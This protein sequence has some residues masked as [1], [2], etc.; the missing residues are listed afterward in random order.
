MASMNAGI[1]L[2]GQQPNFLDIVQRGN[3]AAQQQNQFTRQN[4]LNALYRDQGAQIAQ[5]DQGALNALAGF[6]PSA[7][8][9]VQ[10]ARLGMDQTRQNMQ[11]NRE[12][13]AL[14]KQNAARQAQQYVAQMGAE[15]AAQEAEQIKRGL[16]AAGRAFDAGDEAGFQ[17]ILR[18]NGVDPFPMEEFPYRAAEYAGVLETLEKANSYGK[19]PA[20]EY[21]VTDGQFYDKNNPQAG[22]Q[23]LPGFKAEPRAPLVS[24]VIGGGDE[25]YK[26]LDKAQGDMFGSL[27]QQGVEAPAKLAQIDQLEAYLGDASTPEGIEA[28]L[29]AFAGDLGIPTEGLDKLQAARAIISQLVP[30]QRPPGSGTMSDA[31]LAL[32]QQSLPRMINTREGNLMIIRTLRGIAQYEIG[33]AQ[34]AAALANREISPAEA[35]K[36]LSELENPL[37]V[38]RGGGETKVGG[39][40]S[41]EAQSLIDRYAQ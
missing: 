26:T 30:G 15:Q 5:G 18:A 25:L 13:L 34:I 28:S 7:A 38:Y 33:Q 19:P 41:P 9:G 20:P 21:A 1:I 8:L 17:A 6:D 11:I 35:R 12:E 39:G 10:S 22:A 31:D 4:Q 16:T 14:R 29:K 36:A 32:F 24:N 2:A 23:P 40:F 3:E 27:I 37:Q